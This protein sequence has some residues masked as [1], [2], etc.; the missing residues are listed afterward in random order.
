[1]PVRQRLGIG[2][3]GAIVRGSWST[4]T[5]G[6]RRLAYLQ[7]NDKAVLVYS[8]FP[9][10]DIAEKEGA[11]LVEAGLA[12]CVNII[13]GMVS[14][15]VWDGKRHRDAETVMLIKTRPELADRV[16]EE[17]R[18]RHPYENPALFVIRME[19]G[20]QPFLD[21]IRAQ[22]DMPCTPLGAGSPATE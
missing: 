2:R 6:N 14:I 9:S 7:Q 22:T 19:S 13:P 15:Y 1:M 11:T 3:S 8:T 18:T 21:W 4:R 20:S 5:L 16:V 10:Q 17:V 12:A